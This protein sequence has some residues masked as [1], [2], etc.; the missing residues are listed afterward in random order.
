MFVIQVTVYRTN[1]LLQITVSSKNLKLHSFLSA[2]LLINTLGIKFFSNI[3]HTKDSSYLRNYFVLI[4]N[5]LV[6]I[7]LT[8]ISL[9]I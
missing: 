5:K 1:K 9:Y 4:E 3:I 7:N 2:S 8:V 6:S